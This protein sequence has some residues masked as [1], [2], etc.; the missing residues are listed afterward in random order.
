M[1]LI[2]HC[3]SDRLEYPFFSDIIAVQMSCRFHT[4]YATKILKSD[5]REHLV[6]FQVALTPEYAFSPQ[7]WT[8]LSKMARSVAGL[9][10]RTWVQKQQGWSLTKVCKTWHRQ[11]EASRRVM[12]QRAASEARVASGQMASNVIQSKQS[13]TSSCET[14][15]VLDPKGT[16][17]TQFS[18]HHL[19]YHSFKSE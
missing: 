2:T 4:C 7:H 6:Y 18:H 13:N 14:T 5:F 8:W 10:Y 3:W 12:D 16:H 17:F 9:L 19:P 1:K 15:L 11:Q